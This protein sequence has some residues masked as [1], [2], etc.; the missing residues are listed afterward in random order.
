MQLFSLKPPAIE[1]DQII[2]SSLRLMRGQTYRHTKIAKIIILTSYRPITLHTIRS[3][4]SPMY[5]R[6]PIES[7]IIGT[8]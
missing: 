5:R 1:S 8:D 6:K 7:F 2:F 3:H 4:I